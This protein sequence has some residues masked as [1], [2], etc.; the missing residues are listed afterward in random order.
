MKTKENF[1]V[2]VDVPR[3]GIIDRD[4]NRRERSEYRDAKALLE[5][6]NRHCDGEGARIE[7]DE[8]CSHCGRPWETDPHADGEPVCCDKAQEEFKA[9]KAS[10]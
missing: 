8:V 10:A 4:L 9:V 1:R 5:Q 7:Y 6:V 3:H 2:V